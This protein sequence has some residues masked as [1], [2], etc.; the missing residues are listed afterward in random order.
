VRVSLQFVGRLDEEI[1]VDP[2]K[3]IAFARRQAR[4]GRTPSKNITVATGDPGAGAGRE[5]IYVQ[6]GHRL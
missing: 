6:C 1:L 3:L 4:A 5:G 2:K